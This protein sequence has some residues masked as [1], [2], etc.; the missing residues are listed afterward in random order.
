LITDASYTTDETGLETRV[1]NGNGA[2]VFPMFI[3]YIPAGAFSYYWSF[4]STAYKAMSFLPMDYEYAGNTE[5]AQCYWIRK[6]DSDNTVYLDAWVSL[7]DPESVDL[8]LVP[9]DNPKSVLTPTT[10]IQNVVSNYV[11]QGDTIGTNWM[12]SDGV[13]GFPTHML[14]RW[15]FISGQLNIDYLAV[16]YAQLSI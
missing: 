3:D 8:S 16:K 14:A 2:S 11:L 5:R 1:A 13:M 4:H 6:S 10:Q 15:P 9:N 12:P 7:I